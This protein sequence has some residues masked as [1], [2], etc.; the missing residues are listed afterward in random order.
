MH[1]TSRTDDGDDYDDDSDD[2]DDD[3]NDADSDEFN[4]MGTYSIKPIHLSVFAILAIIIL[5]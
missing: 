5:D 3:D 2:G 4:V 1:V